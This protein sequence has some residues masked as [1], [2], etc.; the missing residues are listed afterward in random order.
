MVVLWLVK[1]LGPGGMERLLVHHARLSTCG[2]RFVVAYLVE[3]PN[4]LSGELRDLGV[5][6][7][8]LHGGPAWPL[9]LRRLVK[10]EQVAVVHA[11]SPLMATG[12]RLALRTTLRHRP[13]LVYTE[14]NTWASHSRVTRVLNAAT[15]RLDDHQLAV[16][17]KSRDDGRRFA[18]QPPEL[19]THGID[20][21]ALRQAAMVDP[22]T[23]RRELG[24]TD[25]SLLVINVAN[26]RAPKGHEVLLAAARLVHERGTKVRW[27]CVG[28]GPRAGELAAMRD[29]LGLAGVV[30]FLGF[31]AD[32]AALVRAAD[33]LVLSSHEEG[34]PLAVMEALTLGVPVVATAVGGVPSIIAAGE[35]GLLVPPG[36]PVDL[37]DAVE[38]LAAEPELRRR[39]ASGA[40]RDPD[41]FDARGAVARIDA[42]YAE[43]SERRNRL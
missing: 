35:N 30:D 38:R 40:Q 1:G 28:H 10:S 8:R 22:L 7:V 4:S 43:V 14:H 25:P 32:V 24:V 41:R 42:I 9:H 33:V 2:Y 31:R 17:A 37:A 21:S 13:A 11:H 15:Y 3:R 34:L 27:I 12:A 19:L 18:R 26:L 29:E 23:M 6:V 39:L 5:K 20:A 16:S 36:S